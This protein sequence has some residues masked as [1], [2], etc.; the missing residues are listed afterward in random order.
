MKK[1]SALI[2]LS[3]I[4]MLSPCR[5][6]AEVLPVPAEQ[7]S[8]AYKKKLDDIN[9]QVEAINNKIIALKQ[10]KKSLLN[11]I[12]D[13]ELRYE[14]EVIEMNKVL[15]QL[16]NAEEKISVKEAEKKVLETK[17]E[18]SKEK[19]KKI[20]RI[21]YKIGGNTYLKIFIRVDTIDQ[22][23][24]NYHLFMSLI[25]YKSEEI[26]KIKANI[27]LLNN[28]TMQ[29]QAE[30]SKLQGF[31][32]LQEQKMRNIRG[33][34]QEKLNLVKKINADKDDHMQLLEELR[35]EAARL[36]E[37]LSGRKVKSS[38]KVIDL[39]KIKGRLSWPVD[40]KVISS[41]GKKKS[42]RF[43]TY[44]FNNGIEINLTTS[45][46]IKA[47]YAGD[48]VYAEYY[49]GYGNLVIIQHSR[50]LH[51]LYG[52]CKEILKKPGDS[53]V[54]GEEIAVAGDTGSTSGK[55]LYFEI[56]LHLKSQDPLEWLKKKR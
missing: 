50:D 1:I 38:L 16:R 2:L 17:I 11:E 36:H 19:L 12:Y 44:I 46:R 3:F 9:N 34:K 13:I 45:D 14:K 24:K 29:L 5:F 21:L 22:L 10:E 26:D 15:L 6:Q 39:K 25:R 32:Q 31:K 52:H 33:L 27:L 23:F 53:I 41:F 7:E 51:S 55:S 37:V 43:D 56:R 30:Y 28:V 40:G 35:Y 4:F 49:K 18:E 47:V 54:S 48:V 8:A 20:M 42:T